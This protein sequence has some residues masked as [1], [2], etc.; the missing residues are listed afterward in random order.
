MDQ[1]KLTSTLERARHEPSGSCTLPNSRVCPTCRSIVHGCYL[2]VG[3]AVCHERALGVTLRN[4]LWECLSCCL[5]F[6]AHLNLTYSDYLICD[7]P[8]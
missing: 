2:R 3:R 5:L 8:Y 4:L 1:E 7:L 6:M